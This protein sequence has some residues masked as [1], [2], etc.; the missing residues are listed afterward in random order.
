MPV[1]T[2]LVAGSLALALPLVAA[3]GCGAAKKR[4]IK[5]ELKAAGQHLADSSAT[6]VT[7][8][9]T[10][11][12]GNLAKEAANGSDLD[13]SAV[14][15]LLGSSVTYTFDG[16]SA[17]KVKSVDASASESELKADLA[18]VHLSLVVKD[19]V[20]ALGEIRLVDSTL[21]ARVDVAEIDKLAREAGSDGFASGFDDF[22]SSAPAQYQPALKDVKAG[23]WM[24]LPLSGY[25]GKLQEGLKSLP[26]AAPKSELQGTG[27][28]LLDAVKPY[29][30][31]T[32]ANDS[33][34]NR[35]LDVTV[36][37]RPAVKAA[38]KV[39][40]GAPGLPFA[41][42]LKKVSGADVDKGLAA[43]KARGTITLSDG[44]LKQVAID[45]DS[46]RRLD[47][48]AS[49]S[50]DLAGSDVVLDVD[51]SADAVTAPTDDV[52]GADVKALLEDLFSQFTSGFGTS[53]RQTS[54]TYA[55]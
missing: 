11:G 33:S 20:K 34:S 37:A 42:E 52:S 38:L 46:I 1:P 41:S 19:A 54:G 44:H 51:D 6:S 31:V 35:V 45:I 40:Q 22:I 3:A 5:E 36:D 17:A 23:K 15:D 24:K 10:D 25:V 26:S 16:K 47:P 53:V 27:R 12:K 9:L 18:D 49:T 28:Q 8:R 14:K 21:F 55:G 43:G 50:T 30:K 39:L 32:D 13:P 2:R 4:S 29:V 48:K 7:L